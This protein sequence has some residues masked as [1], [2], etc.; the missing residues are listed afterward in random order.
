MGR[1]RRAR[2]I[3][4]TAAYGGGIGAAGIGA[5]GLIGYG[6]LKVE[7]LLARRIVVGS[8]RRPCP[9][10]GSLSVMTCPPASVCCVVGQP[11][12]GQV[13]RARYAA[14]SSSEAASPASVT[15]TSYI[16]PSP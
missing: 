16:H 14:M 3:A 9:C 1:A 5:L 4:A 6:V 8:F 2:K 15:F 10:S 11:G 13:R 7:A 12:D